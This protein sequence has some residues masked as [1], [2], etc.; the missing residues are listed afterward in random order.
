MLWWRSSRAKSMINFLTVKCVI[1]KINFRQYFDTIHM[2]AS[3]GLIHIILIS[4]ISFA[5]VLKYIR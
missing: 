1:F 5:W 3:L 4:S 2:H